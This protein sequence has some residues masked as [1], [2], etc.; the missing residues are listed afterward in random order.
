MSLINLSNIPNNAICGLSDEML[1]C[2]T[3][4]SGDR[5]VEELSTSFAREIENLEI[6]EDVDDDMLKV[7][8]EAESK[9]IPTSTKT[10]TESHIKRFKAFLEENKLST[11]IE[12]VPVEILANYLSFFIFR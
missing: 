5:Y 2:V 7:L 11:K 9:V 4:E 8:R 12:I 10:Q 3:A 6:Y 1:E